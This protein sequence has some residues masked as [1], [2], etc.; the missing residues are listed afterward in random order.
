MKWKNMAIWFAILLWIPISVLAMESPNNLTLYY[1]P[2]GGRYYHSNQKCTTISSKYWSTMVEYSSSLLELE[3]CITCCEFALPGFSDG[4]WEGPFNL[5]DVIRL[6]ETYYKQCY[7]IALCYMDADIRENPRIRYFNSIAIN[8]EFSK[9]W[10][11]SSDDEITHEQ[12]L[13]LG[14]AALEKCIGIDSHE[15]RK[16]FV[17]AW[18]NIERADNHFWRVDINPLVSNT[19]FLKNTGYF[20]YIDA[21]SGIIYRLNDTKKTSAL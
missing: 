14:Y 12:A 8:E 13:L 2:N 7:E 21:N 16:Y 20:V 15:L 19:K 6:N 9:C 18:L 4:I 11:F 10:G 1:N 5:L 3:P 17:E